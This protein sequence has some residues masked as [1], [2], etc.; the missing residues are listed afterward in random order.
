MTKMSTGWG[1]RGLPHRSCTRQSFG[2]SSCFTLCLR[3]TMLRGS[4]DFDGGQL[5]VIFNLQCAVHFRLL[6]LA[7][8][9]DNL[10][11]V[12]DVFNCYP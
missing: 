4:K 10:K 11:L 12:N 2:P 1:Q 9:M 3:C 8:N 6:M 5:Q 7:C